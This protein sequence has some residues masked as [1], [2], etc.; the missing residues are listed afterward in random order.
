MLKLVIL[1][2]MMIHCIQKEGELL[3]QFMQKFGRF[4]KNNEDLGDYLF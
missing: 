3:L 4:P 2:M 1:T